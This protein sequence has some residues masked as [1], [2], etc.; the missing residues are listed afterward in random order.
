LKFPTRAEFAKSPNQQI[1]PAAKEEE[2]ALHSHFSGSRVR[3][4]WFDLNATEIYQAINHLLARGD[5]T[6]II[7]DNKWVGGIV[8]QYLIS[9]NRISEE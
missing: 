4:E 8:I 6:R 2:A 1:I 3:G 5:E 9:Q 7:V